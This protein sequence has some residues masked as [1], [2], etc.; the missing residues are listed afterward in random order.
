MGSRPEHD[1]EQVAELLALLP[2]AP[3]PW[4]EAAK[5]LPRA[6]R[7]IDQILALAE[8]DAE[9][10]RELIADLEAALREKGFEP[11]RALVD[12]LRSRLPGSNGK[13]S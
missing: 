11:E 12:E 6:R 3:G 10:R 13:H 9:F 1:E 2:P 5:Q 7:G 4:V 8:A